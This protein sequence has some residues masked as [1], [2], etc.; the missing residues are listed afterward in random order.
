MCGRDTPLAS[1]V[2]ERFYLFLLYVRKC[3]P[4]CVSTHHVHTLPLEAREGVSPS[5]TRI[6]DGKSH[7][8][9]VL[10][11]KP[12]SSAGAANALNPRAI[13][14]SSALSFLRSSGEQSLNKAPTCLCHTWTGYFSRHQQRFSTRRE[15]QNQSPP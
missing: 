10:G 1:R 11:L 8:P 9:R 2:S 7:T 12:R 6:T 5:E 3:L 4:V 13:S 14:S 15:G